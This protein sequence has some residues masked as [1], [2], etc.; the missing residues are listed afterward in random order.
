MNKGLDLIQRTELQFIDGFPTGNLYIGVTEEEYDELEK[1]LK[2]LE[3]INEKD[4]NIRFLKQMF[5]NKGLVKYETYQD[6]LRKDCEEFKSA[7][8]TVSLF[9]LTQE[10]FEL[11]KEVLL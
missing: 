5:Q 11:L 3:I 10:E 1:E 7:Y 4:V 2:V 6:Y 8:L 9:P